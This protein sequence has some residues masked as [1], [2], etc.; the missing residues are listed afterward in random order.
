MKDDV[1]YL[2]RQVLFHSAGLHLVLNTW[3][4]FSE[5]GT[6]YRHIQEWV[7]FGVCTGFTHCGRVHVIHLDCKQKAC[8]QYGVQ[9]SIVKYVCQG[10]IVVAV[11]LPRDTLADVCT[12]TRRVYG[13]SYSTQE[14]VHQYGSFSRREDRFYWK[15]LDSLTRVPFYCSLPL[16]E[17]KLYKLYDDK[18]WSC[19]QIKF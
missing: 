4:S 7:L 16:V 8:F 15:I 3:R 14:K 10:Q 19:A 13:H 5:T 1:L 12:I 6:L 2:H 11:H 18:K 17:I 9:I